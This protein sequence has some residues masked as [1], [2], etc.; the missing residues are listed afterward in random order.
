MCPVLLFASE[1]HSLP[2]EVRRC[3]PGPNPAGGEGE[4]PR[5]GET[6]ALCVPDRG[7]AAEVTGL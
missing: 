5:P 1:E 7:A 4:A 2:G 3:G 6:G